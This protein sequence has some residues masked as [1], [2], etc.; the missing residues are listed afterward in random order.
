VTNQKHTLDFDWIR[1]VKECWISKY[2][3]LPE[4]KDK[5][6]EDIVLQWKTPVYESKSKRNKHKLI[7]LL[8]HADIWINHVESKPKL[9]VMVDGKEPL[10]RYMWSLEYCQRSRWRYQENATQDVEFFIYLSTQDSKH[11]I[12]F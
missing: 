3:D 5:Q 10:V 4:S 6:N 1:R 11:S 12:I 8:S 9:W 7:I 2:H